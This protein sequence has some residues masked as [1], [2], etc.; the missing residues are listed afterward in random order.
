MDLTDLL[1]YEEL[2]ILG[3][4]NKAKCDIIC[5]KTDTESTNKRMDEGMLRSTNKN[6]VHFS[7]SLLDKASSTKNLAKRQRRVSNNFKGYTSQW[8]WSRYMHPVTETT[9]TSQK[10]KIPRE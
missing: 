4:I 1:K 10:L 2:K 7:N 3:L 9:S 5:T 6:K 8:K